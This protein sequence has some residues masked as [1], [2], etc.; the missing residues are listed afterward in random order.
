MINQ[1]RPQIVD[2]LSYSI[3]C[4]GLEGHFCFSTLL[5]SV[6]S[7]RTLSQRLKQLEK[8]GIISKSERVYSL[9]DKGGK[10][11]LLLQ[12]T[13]E[14]LFEDKQEQRTFQCERIPAIWKTLQEYV[15]HLKTLPIDI[16]AVILFGSYATNQFKPESDLDLLIVA[17]GL[18]SSRWERSRLFVNARMAFRSRILDMMTTSSISFRPQH[19]AI[20]PEEVDRD[21]SLFLDI[22]QDGVVLYQKGK[23]GDEILGEWRRRLLSYE[24]RYSPQHVRYWKRE[25]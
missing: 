13:H 5:G 2:P 6:R 10:L 11:A 24:C 9:T 21:Y 7:P 4:R 16:L 18:S 25:G 3:L 12:Q 17:S 14:V 1:I 23:C 19:L 20:D 22:A 15:D 8:L